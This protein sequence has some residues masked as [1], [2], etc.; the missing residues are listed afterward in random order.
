M[1]ESGMARGG[2][3]CVAEQGPRDTGGVLPWPP[4]SNKM[5][6]EQRNI[7]TLTASFDHTEVLQLNSHLETKKIH[8]VNKRIIGLHLY[9]SESSTSQKKENTS[10]SSFIID[11]YTT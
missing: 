3:V 10:T 6:R 5:E 1:E 11:L 4:G 8:K 9:T 7:T 2:G